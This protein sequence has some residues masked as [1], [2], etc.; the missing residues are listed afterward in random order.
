MSTDCCNWDSAGVPP[1]SAFL[2][3]A[4]QTFLNVSNEKLV[5][6]DVPKVRNWRLSQKL[7]VLEAAATAAAEGKLL[8]AYGLPLPTIEPDVPDP[9]LA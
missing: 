9:W 2:R 7:E 6:N 8:N 3:C 1:I 4:P 5:K